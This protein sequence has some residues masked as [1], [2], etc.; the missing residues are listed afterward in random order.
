VFFYPTA[1]KKD[2][3]QAKARRVLAE[4]QASFA[5]IHR[6]AKFDMLFSEIQRKIQDKCAAMDTKGRDEI[7]LDELFED[8][9]NAITHLKDLQAQL[10]DGLPKPCLP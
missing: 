6:T 7:L 2:D 8:L 10:D 9:K 5:N 1:P 4:V 3:D